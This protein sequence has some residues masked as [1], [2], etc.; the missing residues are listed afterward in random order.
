[1]ALQ[2]TGGSHR[3]DNHCGIIFLIMIRPE[4]LAR[5]RDFEKIPEANH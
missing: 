4:A 1:M 2:K 5:H 3:V